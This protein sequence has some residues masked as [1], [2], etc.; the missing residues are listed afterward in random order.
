MDWVA[1]RWILGR[2]A[3][4]REGSF[5]KKAHVGLVLAAVMV[6]VT[7]FTGCRLESDTPVVDN[8]KIT[9][10]AENTL[11][12]CSDGIDNDGD[13]LLDCDDP[14]C[15]ALGTAEV[16]GPGMTVCPS[17]ENNIYV[18]ADGKDNDGDSFVDCED[19]SC[20]ATA[21][22]C[23]ARAE[24][25]SMETCSDGLDND[26]NGYVDCADYACSKSSNKAV[27]EYCRSLKCP[28][29]VEQENSF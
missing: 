10:G 2:V 8:P 18:C 21:S 24:E 22:C 20:K 16:P 15:R 5:M 29:G 12:T 27:E 3:M 9:Q 23:V 7:S 14:D 11:L 1:L 28:S 6:V 19:N 25:G 26:C 13:T 17:E 4:D